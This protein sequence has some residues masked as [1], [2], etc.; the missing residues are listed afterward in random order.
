MMPDLLAM[1]RR[2]GYTFVSLE[3]A[4]GDP[5]YQLPD[6]YVGRTEFPGS[7]AGQ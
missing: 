3:H 5:A 4:L 2:R 7:I 1:F 6:G